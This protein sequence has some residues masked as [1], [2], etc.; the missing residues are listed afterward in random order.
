MREGKAVPQEDKPVR[1]TL[2]DTKEAAK[3]IGMS[4]EWINKQIQK[5][6]LPFPYHS[7]GLRKRLFDSADLEDWQRITKNP[8]GK[9]P[10]GV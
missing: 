8:A 5:G 6:K 4:A 9:K 1:G 7:P 2:L 10:E 3:K